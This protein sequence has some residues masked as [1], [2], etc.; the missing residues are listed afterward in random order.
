M[1]T[2]HSGSEFFPANPVLDA[3]IREVLMSGPEIARRLLR[4]IPRDRPVRAASASAALADYVRRKYQSRHIDLVIAMT[5][6][7][8]PVRAGSPRRAVS[9]RADRLRRDRRAGRERP[10]RRDGCGIAVVRVGSAYV[11]TLKLALE[12]HPS[13]ERVFVVAQSPNQQNVDSVRAQLSEFSRQVQLT[14]VDGG[15]A[16]ARRWR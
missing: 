8:A 13:T 10:R 2:V 3:A 6:D 9:R 16:A 5:N 15:D 11:E 7:C 12:L 1:L 4:G 14:Y